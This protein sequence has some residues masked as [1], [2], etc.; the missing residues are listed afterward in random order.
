MGGG[1]LTDFRGEKKKIEERKL[2]D[3]LPKPGI[4]ALNLHR[5]ALQQYDILRKRENL[6]TYS[7]P[8]T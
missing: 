2:R 4:G 3:Q 5:T 1:K 7:S 6:L 8:E